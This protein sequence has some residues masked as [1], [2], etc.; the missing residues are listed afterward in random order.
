MLPKLLL[1][2]AHD[3]VD[4]KTSCLVI[5]GQSVQL[6]FLRAFSPK[7]A[8]HEHVWTFLTL[9]GIVDFCEKVYFYELSVGTPTT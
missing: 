9:D 5:S 4:D 1:S 2:L 7:W 6:L 3:F 8:L